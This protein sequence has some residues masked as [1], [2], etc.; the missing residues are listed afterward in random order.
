MSVL[1]YLGTV[2]MQMFMNEICL[3][4]QVIV[5]QNVPALTNLLYSVLLGQEEGLQV[6]YLEHFHYPE[7][8]VHGLSLANLELQRTVEQ[9]IKDCRAEQLN[10]R[11]LKYITDTLSEVFEKTPV[12]ECAL[13]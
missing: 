9:F 3:E 2:Y 13:R 7:R 6:F 1:V 5:F 4:Q 12:P 8:P 10:V 11:I